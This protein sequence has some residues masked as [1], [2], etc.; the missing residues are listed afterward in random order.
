LR[1]VIEHFETSD[2]IND[3][4]LQR[5]PQAET[6][7]GEFVKATR[8]RVNDRKAEEYE[9]A[10]LILVNSEFVRRSFVEGGVREKKS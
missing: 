2:R 3:E 6:R 10:D 1:Q 7:Y 4:E 5:F 9:L 8:S